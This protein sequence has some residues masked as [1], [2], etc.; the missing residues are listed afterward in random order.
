M[1]EETVRRLG[2]LALGIF[3]LA[4]VALGLARE[5]RSPALSMVLNQAQGAAAWWSL[6]P[7]Y[8]SGWPVK[9]IVLPVS[10]GGS[11]SQF[12]AHC[13]ETSLNPNPSICPL[14]SYADLY[15]TSNPSQV[16]SARI[17]QPGY[18]YGYRPAQGPTYSGSLPTVT[19]GTSLTLDWACQDFQQVTVSYNGGGCTSYDAFGN[20][21]SY[22]G[23]STYTAYFF[24]Y[25]AAI[26]GG[27]S[28]S[29]LGSMTVTPTQTTTYTVYCQ[30]NP[31]GGINPAL[32]NTPTM[33]FTVNVSIPPTPTLA[34]TAGGK[35]P[36]DTVYAGQPVTIAAT[37][38]PGAGDTLADTAIND[39]M[40]NLWCG[41]GNTCSASMWTQAP[42]GSKSY[43]FTPSSPGLYLF[44]PAAVTATYPWWNNYGSFLFLNVVNQCTN[45]QGPAGACTS[46][47]AGYVLS[48]GMCVPQCTNGQGPAGACT[49]CN[50][51]YV[52]SA[53]YCTPQCA[54]GQGASGSC[55]SCNAGYVL[56]GGYCVVPQ[57][58]ITTALFASPSRVR[59]GTSTSLSWATSNMTSCSVTDEV[60]ATISTQLS[61][62]GTPANNITHQK[63]FTLSCTDG[64][65][66][67]TSQATV[68]VLPSFQEI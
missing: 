12:A 23:G 34:I 57:G 13:G 64:V 42:M 53:G 28:K 36:P 32:P 18:Y 17:I 6:Y 30:A 39:F 49:S 16:V 68:N 26:V 40:G 21:S 22:A 15:V 43:T 65:K 25:I 45:G 31:N 2:V 7:Q 10:A 54:N 19:A 38:T 61:S 56:M 14:P 1:N 48:A 27:S 55:T 11:V 37:F 62:S 67:Y 24:D 63:I 9:H 29:N 41:T 47:N 3:L 66:T 35:N 46:C 4:G 5:V 58:V 33:S 60:G 44:Y 59:P 51:G 50:P 52:L 20:C 8:D